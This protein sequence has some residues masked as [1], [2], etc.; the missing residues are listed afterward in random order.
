MAAAARLLF[1]SNGHGED[2]IACQLLDRMRALDASTP[3]DAWPM[4]GDGAAYAERGVPI[5]GPRN[6]LPSDGFATLSLAL[7]WKDLRA[8]WVRTHLRQVA[9]ARALRGRYDLVLAVG[10]VVPIAAAVLA[11]TPFVFVGCAKSAYYGPRWG[12][13]ALERRWLAR[14]CVTAYARDRLTANELAAARVPA[15]YVGNPMMDDLEGRGATFSLAADEL[16]IACLPGSR[17]DAPENARRLLALVPRGERLGARVTYLLAV[18]PS[19]D[20]GELGA[21]AL[22]ALGWRDVP[23]GE[24]DA[25]DGIVR[26]LARD[27]TTRALVVRAPGAFA[28]ALRRS[29]LVIGMAGTANEQ[30]VG[31]GRPLVVVP[32]AGGQGQAF[33]RM[34]MRYFGES[35]VRGSEE[36][37]AFAE[38]VTSLLRDD[39]RRARMAAAGRERMGEPG[40]SDAIAR[41]V[42]ARLAR[43]DRGAA[44]AATRGEARGSP[45]HAGGAT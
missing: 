10:D 4:V 33:V 17:G 29:T 42:L 35:A 14:H 21:A 3:I 37:R 23:P 1:V 24:D 26:R 20:A 38:C 8:G 5:V 44:A 13:T 11:R 40:A 7:L 27:A 30:A 41:D 39:A 36:P 28:D 31:L 9:A 12:Y 32:A 45:A 2:A 25:A 18:A 34:K 6:R 15:R 16:V 19:F 43:P 22:D